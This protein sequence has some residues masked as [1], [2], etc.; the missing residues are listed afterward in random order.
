MFWIEKSKRILLL[1][2]HLLD[3]IGLPL[4]KSTVSRKLRLQCPILAILEQIATIPLDDVPSSGGEV[5]RLQRM[6]M[7]FVHGALN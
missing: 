6:P 4:S 2:L 1:P 5:S 7:R 3:M